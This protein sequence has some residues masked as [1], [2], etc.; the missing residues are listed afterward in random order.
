MK[1]TFDRNNML[2]EVAIAQEII[3][4]KSPIAI[5]SCVWLKAS[6]DTLTLRATDT[7]INFSTNINISTK[8]E[9]ETT[10]FCD[11]FMSVLGALPSGDA[12]FETDEEGAIIT[13]CVK[14]VHFT[15]R[16][17]AQDKFP[18]MKE[19][20]GKTFSL[21]AKEFKDLVKQTIFAVS[22]DP[23]RFFMTGVDFTKTEKGFTMVA[24][25]ARRLAIASCPMEE[26]P[27]ESAIVP[28][29]ILRLVQK[30]ASDEGDLS[31]TVS[32]TDISIKFNDYE[33]TSRLIDGQFPNYKKVI[34]E[35]FKCTFNVNK[36]DLDEALKR[37]DIMT[38]KKS[39]KMIFN[40][41]NDVIKIAS[42]QSQ[43]GEALEEVPCTYI[44]DDVTIAFSN[45]FLS[46][47][48]HAMDGE[49]VIFEFTDPQHAITLKDSKFDYYQDVIMP[50][51]IV[52]D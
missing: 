34:P 42:R 52:E 6:G 21:G 27:I 23:N 29:K 19:I 41:T 51:S 47:P 11:K 15:I 50:M 4:N 25:D 3:T 45:K 16:S 46:E 28:T 49:T 13:S 18:V 17:V 24:T 26:V 38:D 35:S 5:L 22:V 7:C 9:G 8:D 40:I 36:N 1:F 33:F 12:I 31:I 48:L 20:E 39:G 44:G 2:R 43:L 14:K 10:I 32:E 37:M 30:T